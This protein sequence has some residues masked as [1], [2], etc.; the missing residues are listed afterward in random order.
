M[1]VDQ[2]AGVRRFV[3]PA[4]LPVCNRQA[5]GRRKRESP[6]TSFPHGSTPLEW[7]HAGIQGLMRWV[8]VRRT[9]VMLLER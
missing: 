3:I 1:V 7:S 2:P 4:C 6:S 5:A 8:F 9:A